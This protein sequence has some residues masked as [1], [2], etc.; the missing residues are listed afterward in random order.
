MISQFLHAMRNVSVEGLNVKLCW[1]FCDR[2]SSC[3]A[4]AERIWFN[5]LQNQ[6]E[7]LRVTPMWKE[8]G[9]IMCRM[10]KNMCL[11]NIIDNTYQINAHSKLWRSTR[12]L[13]L[14]FKTLFY[15]LITL[16]QLHPP[17]TISQMLYPNMIYI[18]L[19]FYMP[20]NACLNYWLMSVYLECNYT[21]VYF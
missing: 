10:K 1:V 15:F 6:K 3:Y 9:L 2:N 16:I 11:N 5:Y 21:L 8:G 4:N 19:L 14:Y 18:A 20:R 13:D 12:T 7:M 17:H